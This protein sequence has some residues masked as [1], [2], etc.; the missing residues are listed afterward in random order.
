M[1]IVKIV[2]LSLSGALLLFVGS[3]RLINPIKNYLKNSGIKLNKDVDL[4]NEVRGVSALMLCGG[5]IT[6]LGIVI[7]E[8]TTA[9]FIVATLIYI[10]FAIGRI[11][12]INVD[13]KPNKQIVQ[14]LVFELV[15]GSANI[16]C[17]LTIML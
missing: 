6:I 10:G 2:I 4:L 11:I 5:V 14:G 1:E 12:S 8:I 9:S 17:L 7:P 3:T 13:G 15:L 16:Y